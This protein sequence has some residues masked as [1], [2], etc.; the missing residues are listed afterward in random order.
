[1]ETNERRFALLVDSENASPSDIK[2][3]IEQLNVLG[4][5]LYKRVYG[6]FTSMQSSSWKQPINEFSLTPIQQ[7]SYT[8][9]KNAT[10][11]KMIID[12]MDILYSGHVNAFCIMSSDS[13]F[14]S[15]AKRLKESGIFVC[16]AGKATTPQSFVTSCDR[17]F[18][19][20]DG[21]EKKAKLGSL[22]AEK[23]KQ[24]E[25][26]PDEVKEEI[27]I[28]HI[29]RIFS[30][31]DDPEILLSNLMNTIYRT[32]PNFESKDY[33]YKRPIDFFR[34]HPEFHISRN[35]KTGAYLIAMSEL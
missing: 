12:A 32:F 34:K 23:S 7:F 15:I 21:K 25:A 24:P 26:Q 9:G 6:D 13:D 19:L 4:N 11:S 27:V 2:E 28:Q 5:I 33:G 10:D 18:T 3:L 29:K 22:S 1:M 17:F 35:P 14:T 30:S 16:G 20:L 31:H 8:N